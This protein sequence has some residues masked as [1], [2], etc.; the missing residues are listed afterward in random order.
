MSISIATM[1]KFWPAIGTGTGTSRPVIIDRGSSG[2]GYS[3]RQPKPQIIVRN[4]DFD[5]EVDVMITLLNVE[6]N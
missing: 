1:G 5:N 2:Y 6:E 4:V 3:E